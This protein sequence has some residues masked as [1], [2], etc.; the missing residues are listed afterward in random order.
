MY[1]LF[2]PYPQSFND[3]L[4]N[5][6]NL[7]DLSLITGLQYIPDYIS[8]VE[9]TQFLESINNEIWLNDLKRRVQHYGFKYD[10]KARSIDKSMFIGPLPSWAL[11]IAKKLN[12]DGF[13]DVIPDQL[14]INEYLPGQGIANHVDCVPCF[15]DT[16]ISISLGS[17]CIMDFINLSN[18]RKIEVKLDSGS[19]VVMKGESRKFWTHGIAQRKTDSFK[20][21][22]ITRSLRISMTFR[23]VII[24]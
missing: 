10:Y 16:I 17:S 15:G 3:D 13:I 19:L 20:G 9:V 24:K 1:D 2:N 18:K 11:T 22:K 4:D 12:S 6:G 23:K 7:N 5:S 21:Q 14:I 8:K